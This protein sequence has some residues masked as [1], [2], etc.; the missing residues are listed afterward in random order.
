MGFP[1]RDKLGK[2][3]ILNK[4]YDNGK[5]QLRQKGGLLDYILIIYDII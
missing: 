4:F 3:G 1:E 5:S 2:S